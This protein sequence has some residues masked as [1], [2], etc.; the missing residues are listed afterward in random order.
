M[1]P[2]ARPLAHTTAT[3][4]SHNRFFI[5]R[6]PFDIILEFLQDFHPKNSFSGYSHYIEGKSSK[7]I[8]ILPKTSLPK[9]LCCTISQGIVAILHL[10]WAQKTISCVQKLERI[11]YFFDFRRKN[12]K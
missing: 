12:P 2:M 7:T 5:A 8:G 6:T 9:P 4:F 11:S 10:F 3:N 1:T